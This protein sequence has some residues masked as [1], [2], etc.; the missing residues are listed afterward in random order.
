MYVVRTKYRNTNYS[1]G[2]QVQVE[3][4][5]RKKQIFRKNQTKMFDAQT[6]TLA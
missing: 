1:I 4:K 6:L 5:H 2:K 3:T